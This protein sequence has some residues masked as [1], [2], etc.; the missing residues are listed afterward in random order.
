M[1]A[2]I[3]DVLDVE[4]DLDEFEQLRGAARDH[5]YMQV[6]RAVRRLHALQAAMIDRVERTG[7]YSDDGH[8]NVTCWLSA[9]ANCSRGTARQHVNVAHLCRD[10]PNVAQA[11]ADGDIGPDQLRLLTDLHGNDRV[12]HLLPDSA[13]LLADLAAT[14]RVEDFKKCTERWLAHADPDGQHRD[15]DDAV[16]HRR[17]RFSR[18]GH[19]AEMHL[20]TDA[21]TAAIINDIV[22]AH[23]QAEFLTDVE[24]NRATH[25]N[26]AN[27]HP[28]PRTA[29]QRQHDAL[30]AIILKSADTTT[31]TSREPLV[32]IV[33]TEAELNDAV[34]RHYGN[35]D[36]HAS[37]TSTSNIGGAVP[38]GMRLCETVDG[39]PVDPADM[40]VAALT[41]YIRRVVVDSAGRVI[42]LG[43]RCRLFRGAAREAVLL[44]GHA[45][46]V[47][48]C[49]LHVPNLHIDHIAPWAQAGHTNPGNGAPECPHHNTVKHTLG[50]TVTRD[51]TGWHFYRADGTEIA[52]RP[53]RRK[54]P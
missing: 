7:S 27:K 5:A 15:H 20:D 12:R 45:C 28:L 41:G 9:V 29:A 14:L 23:T 48:G 26:D 37:T 6:E 31:T 24:T 30:L 47:P 49:G 42:D 11:C 21:V 16:K 19:H 52:P 46:N 8:R 18:V 22:N 33:V 13:D 50:I 51:E 17:L 38:P 35:T 53:T 10:L 54:P 3:D 39:V 32:N 4:L 2:V 1:S 34:R 43:R 36:Q 25:G 44:G 40:L